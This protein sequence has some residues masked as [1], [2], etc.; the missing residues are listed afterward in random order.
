MVFVC[1]E[2]G[3]RTSCP[4]GTNDK[5]KQ[6]HK[7][8]LSD[9]LAKLEA[10]IWQCVLEASQAFFMDCTWNIYRFKEKELGP[11]SPQQNIQQQPQIT[12]ASSGQEKK[13][14]GS[15]GRYLP[16]LYQSKGGFRSQQNTA[17]SLADMGHFSRQWTWG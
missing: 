15:H 8:H 13:W 2:G 10:S 6:T 5:T 9:Q 16:E 12:L 3:L 17:V 4:V 14:Y 1:K 11:K 7:I